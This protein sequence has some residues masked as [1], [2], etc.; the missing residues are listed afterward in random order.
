MTDV[1][2]KVDNTVDNH[3]VKMYNQNGKLSDGVGL[4]KLINSYSKEIATDNITDVT[5][6]D[7]LL[8]LDLSYLSL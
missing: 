5:T 7:I 8:L 6:T 3:N 1:K 4:S 2:I